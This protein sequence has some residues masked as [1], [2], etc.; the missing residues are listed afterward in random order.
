[1]NPAYFIVTHLGAL[2]IL[3][4]FW[5]HWDS[6]NSERFSMSYLL[7]IP[8]NHYFFTALLPPRTQPRRGGIGLYS[9]R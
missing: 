4:F 7:D 9:Y 6:M 2:K 5:I 8:H 3:R 1:M